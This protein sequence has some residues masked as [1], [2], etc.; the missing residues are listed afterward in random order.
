MTNSIARRT[1]EIKIEMPEACIQIHYFRTDDASGIEAY[2]KDRFK[3]K[4]TNPKGEWFRLTAEDIKA[5][6]RRKT[7]M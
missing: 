2:W 4:R 5:F 6:K 1:A 7:F 3:S